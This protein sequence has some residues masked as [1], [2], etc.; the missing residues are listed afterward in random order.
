MVSIVNFTAFCFIVFI[1]IL[2]FLAFKEA[3]GFGGQNIENGDNTMQI[4]GGYLRD[5]NLRPDRSFKC[6]VGNLIYG[7]LGLKTIY[8]LLYLVMDSSVKFLLI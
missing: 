4:K 8:E 3:A 7:G 2:M 1:V 6:C 5:N